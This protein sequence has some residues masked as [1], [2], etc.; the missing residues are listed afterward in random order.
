MRK[1]LFLFVFIMLAGF[2]N[3]IIGQ[4][5]NFDLF[6]YHLYNGYAL[7][8]QRYAIDLMPAGIHTFL[9]PYL[10]MIYYIFIKIF[11]LHP[12]LLNFIQGFS[13]G[14]ILFVMLLLSNKIF[15]NDK[16][17]F[18][19]AFIIS[20]TDAVLFSFVGSIF[21]DLIIA[22]FILMGLIIFINN[23]K[24]EK[25]YLLHFY[26]IGNLFGLA[27]VCKF[28]G[29]LYYLALLISI[30]ILKKDIPDFKKKIFILILSF[31]TTYTIFN[32]YFILFLY[33]TFKNP[34]FPLF[35]NIFHSNF[36]PNINSNNFNGYPQTIFQYL[37]YPFYWLNFTHKYICEGKFIDLRFITIYL[38]IICLFIKDKKLLTL[39]FNENFIL[40]FSIISYSFWLITFPY[41]RYLTPIIAISGII[42]IS[43]AIKLHFSKKYLMLLTILLIFCQYPPKWNKINYYKKAYEVED[44]KIKDNSN[45][46]LSGNQLSYI[47]PFQN[48]NAKY[49]NIDFYNTYEYQK[50][51]AIKLSEYKTQ[52]LISTD[53]KN[54]IKI[55]NKYYKG[56]IEG[57]RA[58]NTNFK[59]TKDNKKLETI[60]FCKI[61]NFKING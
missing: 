22:T 20:A 2:L 23:A 6:N 11:N 36:Y 8:N 34:Y 33:K 46:L 25:N 10:D 57:C 17:L 49:I 47:I 52:Y 55:F 37:F 18:L 61:K 28:Y 58:I 42:I 9:N 21:N 56:N 26:I 15:A 40:I 38:L 1:I 7:L 4:D 51:I 39:N 29:L 54:F 5:A 60:Y 14:I 16:Q 13:Y 59:Y 53:L 3:L 27:F 32:V 30:F 48:I 24:K 31:I 43:V 35:N 44:L 50:L 19:F 45:V 12:L 41:I